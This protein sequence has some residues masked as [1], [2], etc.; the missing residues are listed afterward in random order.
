MKTIIS[1]SIA[2]ASLY[3]MTSC[4]G[5]SSQTTANAATNVATMPSDEPS[6]YSAHEI[7]INGAIDHTNWEGGVESTITFERFPKNVQQFEDDMKQLG[8]EPQGAVVLMLM[9]MELYRNDA[10]AGTKCLEMINTDTNLPDVMRQVKDK[11]QGKDSYA[12]PY[13]VAAFMQ[14]ATP[15]NGY[16]P[17]LPYKVKVRTHPVNKYQKSDMLKGYV[18]ELQVYSDGFDSPWRGV[19][20]VKRKGDTHYRIS[21]C[22]AMYTQCKEI[23]WESN[24]EFKGLK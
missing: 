21:N 16:N 5:E 19:H 7:T 24:A 15:E 22:P 10:A 12:R 11:L 6:E 1:I 2:V 23:S 8:Q 4:G 17:T 20:V 9:A 14:G 18:L 3:V 13:L